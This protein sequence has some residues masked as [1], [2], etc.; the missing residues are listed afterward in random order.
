MH[1][2]RCCSLLN[3]VFCD[4]SRAASAVDRRTLN[5]DEH[6]AETRNTHAHVHEVDNR[7]GVLEAQVADLKEQLRGESREPGTAA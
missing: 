4:V 6:Q 3:P 2:S 5:T 7:V 1:I